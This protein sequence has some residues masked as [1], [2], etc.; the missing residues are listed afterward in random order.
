M[1]LRIEVKNSGD[2]ELERLAR[3][4]DRLEVPMRQAG[5]YMER[6]L[7]LGFARQS[8]PDGKPWAALKPSTIARKR[9]SAILRDTGTL[10]GGISLTSVSNSSATVAATAGA[11]YGIYSATGTSRMAQRQFIGIGDRHIPHITK[12]VSSYLEG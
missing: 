7:K 9:S 1:R 11:D 8:D 10:A 2:D 5:L 12:I 6:E 3:K 4:L